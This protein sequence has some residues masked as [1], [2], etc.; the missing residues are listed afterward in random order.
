MFMIGCCFNC[1]VLCKYCRN[2]DPDSE[3]FFDKIG[4][5]A[6]IFSGIISII[7]FW[8]WGWM[9]TDSTEYYDDDDSLGHSE[10]YILRQQRFAHEALK[11]FMITTFIVDFVVDIVHI[12]LDFLNFNNP[13]ICCGYVLMGRC[14]LQAY[15]ISINNNLT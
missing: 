3:S 6:S 2:G 8:L 9:F 13:P 7:L 4:S 11:V 5:F 14:K 10:K 1:F 15:I 12:Y